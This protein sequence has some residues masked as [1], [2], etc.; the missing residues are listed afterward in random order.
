[1]AR[2]NINRI[3]AY[4]I[5]QTC[6]NCNLWKTRRQ[7]VIGRGVV[8]ADVVMLGEGAGRSEDMLGEAFIGKSGKLLDR[9]IDDAKISSNHNPRIL[10][11]NA[12]LCHPTDVKGGDNRRPTPNELD[13]CKNNVLRIVESAKPKAIVF[14][15]ETARKSL[16]RD[17][18]HYSP[19]SIFHPAYVLRQGGESSPKFFH[20]VR[21]LSDLFEQ[22]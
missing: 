13:A 3:K 19:I 5:F 22:L 1:M 12:V 17:L 7:V 8:P 6:T 4:Q 10:L 2:G 16:K 21:L 20:N 14:I 9:M 18:K 15:G 11:T